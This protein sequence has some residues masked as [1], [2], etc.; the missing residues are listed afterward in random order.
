MATLLLSCYLTHVVPH[1]KIIDLPVAGVVTH[2]NGE[3]LQQQ[4]GKHLVI[5]SIA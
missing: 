1:R 4:S 2:A 5:T 3:E